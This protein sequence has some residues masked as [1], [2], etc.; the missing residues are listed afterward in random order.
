MNS[1]PSKQNFEKFVKKGQIFEYVNI[2]K[3]YGHDYILEKRILNEI[4]LLV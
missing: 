2:L 3:S 1:E 4:N